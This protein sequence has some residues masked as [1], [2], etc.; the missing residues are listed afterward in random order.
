M[1]KFVN[2]FFSVVVWICQSCHIDLFK[3]FHRFVKVVLCISRSPFAKQNKA[4]VWQRFQ[5]FL[6]LLL[7]TKG[8]KWVKVLN[9]MGPLCVW[10]CFIVDHTFLVCP[11]HIACIRDISNAICYTRGSPQSYILHSDLTSHYRIGLSKA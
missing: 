3:L 5:S 9:V 11:Y 8:V 1:S 7:W 10:Q 4:E 2:G 6:K